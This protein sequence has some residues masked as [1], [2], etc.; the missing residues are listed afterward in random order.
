[1]A[2][3]SIKLVKGAPKP[4]A[5]FQDIQR[6]IGKQLQAVGRQHVSERK[7]VVDDFETNI[8]FGYRIK[9]SQSQVSLEV[10]LTN[11]SEQVSE[12]F[13]VGDL[14]KALDEGTKGPYPIPKQ[15][16]GK[17]SLA[18]QTNYQPHTRP[19]A[20]GGGPGRATGPMAFPKQVMHPGIKARKFSDTINK[21]LY[22]Q[23]Q[24]AVDRGFRL[25]TAKVR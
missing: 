20:R 19:I 25:A 16:K 21:R 24:K 10:D 7:K 6:E 15:P 5:I 12:G 17:G 11:G 2:I 9:V 23:F 22:K 8:I 1:M 18:F 3:A 13:S 4:E 14:W